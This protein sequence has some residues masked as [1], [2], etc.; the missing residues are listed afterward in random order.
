MVGHIEMSLNVIKCPLVI[1]KMVD[2]DLW[3]MVNK[4]DIMIVDDC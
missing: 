4:G 2:S 1:K 3:L